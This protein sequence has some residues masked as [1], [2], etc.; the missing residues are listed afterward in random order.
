MQNPFPGM[1]PY[2]EQFW[3]DVH[4]RLIVYASNQLQRSLPGDLRA[5]VQERVFVESAKQERSFYPDV[6]VVERG[7]V[8]AAAVKE[9]GGVALAEPVRIRVPDGPITQGYI[10][11]L[12]LSTGR[13]IVTVI[14]ILSAH[15]KVAGR[16]RKLYA[17]KQQECRKG[18]VNLVEI[19]LLRAGR[20][21]LSVPE[22]LVEQPHRTCYKVCIGRGQSSF[23]DF[24]PVSL[25]ERLP[26]I[27]IPLRE[28][29]E[30]VPLDLQTLL[31]QC[32]RDGAYDD[33]IDYEREPNPPLSKDDARW[34]DELLRKKR[35]RVGVAAGRPTRRSRKG[36]T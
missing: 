15:N 30:D 5:R 31:D 13:R 25:R 7:R 27:P 14:E 29:D 1:N 16:G 21:V 22:D 3:G 4:A 8:R 10:E 20:W 19:D 9:N 33:D 34:A 11:I 36:K 26:V 23:W 35:R 17:Q 6:R 24:Y 18:R 2:L 32:Y 28:T 12:D